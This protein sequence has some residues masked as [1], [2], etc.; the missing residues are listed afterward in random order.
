MILADRTIKDGTPSERLVTW[1]PAVGD[2]ELLPLLEAH[3][4]EI[5]SLPADEAGPLPRAIVV[6]RLDRENADF[7]RTL[8]QLRE[9]FGTRVVP[10]A[11]PIGS[12]GELEGAVNL[13]TGRAR[14]TC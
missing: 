1:I 12:N 4:V 8:D 6:T 2:T 9:R 3:D 11:L 10:L 5:T 14:R 7:Q 13:L